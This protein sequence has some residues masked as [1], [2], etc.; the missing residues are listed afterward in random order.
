M[1]KQIDRKISLED[2]ANK[3]TYN[4]KKRMSLFRS[5]SLSER[6]AVFNILS[7]YLRQEIFN[8]LST[9]EAVE[10]LDHLDLRRAHHLLGNIKNPSRRKKI[11]N[12][13]KNDIYLKIEKFLQFHPKSSFS[14]LNL[15]YL[16]LSEETTIRET[17]EIIE[18]YL[19]NV[20]KVPEILIS[21]D[22][23][24]IGQIPLSVLVREDNSKKLKRF[25]K[26]IKTLKYSS[27]S[28]TIITLLSAKPHEKAAVLDNDGSVLGV[29]YSD[30]IIEILEKTPAAGLYSFAGVEE[31]E[32][33]FDGV[34]SKVSH[35]YKWLVLNLGTAFLA[36]G[37]VALFENT[38]AQVVLLAAYMPIVA[39]MGGNAATQTLAVTVR[40]IAIG[41][42]SL[43]NGRPVIIREVLSGL[44]NGLITGV[45][46]AII[47]YLFNQDPML[48]FVVGFAVMISLVAAGF[49]GTIIPLILRSLGKDPATSATIFITTTTDVIGFFVLLGLASLL[50]V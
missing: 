38:M 5:L 47:A 39:G 45:L 46:V 40:G 50:L 41:E 6:S 19:K 17:A 31:S 26:T 42:V 34:W 44:V 20:G 30:D 22:G 2:I 12:Y 33:P 36:A 18:D 9:S 37:V 11:A 4:P 7:P 35:R 25:V 48:G 8:K 15:N 49:F 24:L 3:I 29:V 23:V 21:R 16:F 1:N 32:R 10:I 27:N 28:T 43:K 14:F 13:L